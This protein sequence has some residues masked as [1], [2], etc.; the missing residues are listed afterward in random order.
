MKKFLPLIFAFISLTSYAQVAK[1][2]CGYEASLQAELAKD[3]SLQSRMDQMEADY[4]QALLHPTAKKATT[5]IT[6]PVVVHIVYKNAAQNLSLS[7]I[8]SQIAVLNKD[9]SKTNTDTG[10]VPAAFKPFA[11]DAQIQFAL[12]VRDPQ[13]FP[14]NGITRTQTSISSFDLTL[15]QAKFTAQGGH[16]AW[17]RNSYLNI[18]VVPD[19]NN[20][21][22]SGILGYAQPPGGAAAT[23]GVVIGYQYFGT[24]GATAP[25]NKGRTTTHEVGHWLN[26]RHIWGNNGQACAASDDDQVA[27]TPQQDEENYGCP[28]FPLITKNVP[29][30]FGGPSCSGTAPGSMFMDYMDY[31]D[32]ACMMMFTNGQITRMT[33]AL[34]GPRAS[35]FNSQ[36]LVPVVLQQ[37]DASIKNVTSPVAGSSCVTSITPSF[38]LTNF[39]TD[40]LKSVDIM[41]QVDGGTIDTLA[42]TGTLLSLDDV[43]INLPS[44]NLT[45]GGHNFLVYSMNPNGTS[46]LNT[47][48]DSVEVIFTTINP[49][50]SIQI[51]G[52]NTYV[53]GFDAASFPPTGWT[54][55]NPNNNNTWTRV[56]TASGF[57]NST[58]SARMD[59]YSGTSTAGQIDE[60]L[61]PSF[62][63]NSGNINFY[64]TF[65]V[66]YAQYDATSVDSL[67][68]YTTADCEQTWVRQYGKAKASLAT[69]GGA[70]LTA[71][72]FVPTAT[73]WRTETINLS[74][75]VGQTHARIKFQNKSG[76]G[77]LLYIDDVNVTVSPVGLNESVVPETGVF[78]YPNPSQGLITVAG[79]FKP[80]D[81]WNIKVYDLLG[82]VVYLENGLSSSTNKFNLDLSNQNKGVYFIE[83]A[84]GSQKYT[85]RVSILE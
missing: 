47:S 24:T 53:Q 76:Y 62:D 73:Q 12:A 83:L 51:T 78:V 33:S 39:G 14:T 35:L 63:F 46:D 56:T 13:G 15:N 50:V 64:L 75:L 22:V 68:I 31:V 55:V 5:I 7:R 82:K 80:A 32:D 42:W 36:G 65:S 43:T 85:K 11:G 6:I 58:A 30:G 44:I 8:Q 60:L 17:D 67:I 23:D 69:N 27:D 10:L 70:F 19:I 29:A 72:G 49:P 40:T 18:W 38:S 4:Q 84:N 45:P 3:P 71:S 2:S 26:L 79:N 37:V 74:S 57:G 61:T 59:N 41:Y 66:A 21:G 20:A 48:N 34:N 77:Q 16:D 81:K 54:R 25:F 52:S 1:R 28:T 9:Y